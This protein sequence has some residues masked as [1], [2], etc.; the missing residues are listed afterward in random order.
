[1]Q[2]GEENKRLQTMKI[3]FLIKWRWHLLP[4][5]SREI[6]NVSKR[7]RKEHRKTKNKNVNKNIIHKKNRLSNEYETSEE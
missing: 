6:T 5:F 7:K 2:T 3:N 4:R 1:M